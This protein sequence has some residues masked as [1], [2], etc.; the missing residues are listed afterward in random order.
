MK[1]FRGTL[2]V[3]AIWTV[4]TYAFVQSVR[5]VTNVALTR[6]LSPEL[7]GIMIIINTFKTGAELISDV[8]IGQNIVRSSHSN[9]PAFYNTA[10]T[11]QA[12]RGLLLWLVAGVAAIPLANYYSAAELKTAIPVAALVFVFAGFASLSPFFAQRRMELASLAKFEILVTSLWAIFQ[13]TLA[14][15]FPNIWALVFGLVLGSVISMILSYLVLDAPRTSFL[16]YRNYA[17]EILSFAKWIFVSSIVYFFSVSFDRLFLATTVPLSVLGVYGIARS[18]SDLLNMLVSR[19]TGLILFPFIAAS[20]NVERSDLHSQIRAIR[21]PLLFT[22]ALAFSCFAASADLLVYRV[23]DERYHAAGRMLPFLIIGAWAA[24]ICSVNESMLLGLGKP[25][26]GAIGNVL[27]LCWLLISLPLGFEKFGIF[28]VVVAV[29]A[30]EFMRYPPILVGQIRENFSFAM[31][32]LLLT[33]FMLT[34]LAVFAWIRGWFQV[35]LLF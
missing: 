4:S 34:L 18:I 8:A 12:M 25:K 32:D 14:I 30:G 35:P 20:G 11:L 6:L 17:L 28:G 19:L 22:A 21:L 7:F 15:L 23:F 5:F 26:Y 27:K 31:Q 10:W 16:I 9:E 3:G 24:T 29:S 1:V 2:S 33:S 13:I